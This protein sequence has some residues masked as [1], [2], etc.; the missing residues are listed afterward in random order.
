MIKL[1]FFNK[2]LKKRLSKFDRVVASLVIDYQNKDKITEFSSII[3]KA[4]I[5]IINLM[6]KRYFTKSF[7]E[8]QMETSFTSKT[9]ISNSCNGA[10]IVIS[11][12]Y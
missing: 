10:P 2:N 8:K 1:S 6:L 4:R 12:Y 9:I 11:N 3:Y 5:L 7:D